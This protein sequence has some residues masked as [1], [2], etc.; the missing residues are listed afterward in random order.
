MCGWK[1]VLGLKEMEVIGLK[2]QLKHPLLQCQINLDEPAHKRT[3]T[4]AWTH[5]RTHSHT[6]TH[7]HTHTLIDN[8]SNANRHIVQNKVAAW[9]SALQCVAVCC[10]VLQCVAVCCSV[11]IGI[12]CKTNTNCRNNRLK[13]RHD[14]KRTATHCNTLQHTMTHWNTL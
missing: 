2:R 1:L 5:T 14:S 12:S 8:Q 4:L 13:R 11:P 9:C 7:T 3:H 6:C 10:S